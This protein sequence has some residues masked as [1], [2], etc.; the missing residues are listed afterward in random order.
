M[1]SPKSSV[2]V[3]LFSGLGL[4]GVVYFAPVKEPAVRELETP[5]LLELGE[6]YV[7]PNQIKSKGFKP[8]SGDLE[9]SNTL[10]SLSL[11]LLP[12]VRRERT[13]GSKWNPFVNSGSK[14]DF[15]FSPQ[16]AYVWDA[17]LTGE[18]SL[19]QPNLTTPVHPSA[20][21]IF[22]QMDT[23]RRSLVDPKQ[24]YEYQGSFSPSKF[25]KVQTAVYN[26]KTEN[27]VAAYGAE[28]GKFSFFFGSDKVQLNVKYNYVNARPG[29]APGGQMGFS[30]AQDIASLGLVVFLGS[31]KNYSLYV[32]NQIFNVFNDPL[33]QV[34]DQNGRSPETFSAS[35]RGKHPGKLKTTFFLNFQN[36]FYKD[37]M[38]IG[39]PGGF[40][41]GN[42]FNGKSFYEQV[43]SLGMELAF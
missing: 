5:V 14:L 3:S 41:Y 26:V 21:M 40:M 24:M 31:S 12:G 15:D 6:E 16:S 30:P 42:G 25:L 18:P 32:G 1:H 38:L 27:P 17:K 36:Q 2:F 19:S 33:L 43:T 11:G 34:K 39:V 10:K 13:S 35:F 20:T 29:S 4:L 7:Y 37:G 22:R 23:N 9:Y 8:G 28:G